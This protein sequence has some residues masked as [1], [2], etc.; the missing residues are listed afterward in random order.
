MPGDH[1]SAQILR[2]RGRVGGDLQSLPKQSIGPSFWLDQSTQSLRVGVSNA[3]RG[4]I[5]HAVYAVRLSHLHLFFTPDDGPHHKQLKS[6]KAGL[7]AQT[8]GFSRPVDTGLERRL[9]KAGW[10]GLFAE[11]GQKGGD[12]TNQVPRPRFLE[13][14]RTGS[15]GQGKRLPDRLTDRTADCP[16]V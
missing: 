8:T 4:T 14:R 6:N 7:V 11:G 16:K 10:V 12:K 9:N 13:Y 1:V 2:G 3:L 5:T 15:Y